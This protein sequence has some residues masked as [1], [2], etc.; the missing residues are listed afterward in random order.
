VIESCASGGARVDLGILART[1]RVWA[2]DTND[3]LERQTIQRWTQLLLPPELVGSHVGPPTAHTT[4]RTHRLSFRGATALF[5]HLGIEWDLVSASADERRDVAALVATY[6]THR[7]LL[8]SGTVV[9]ADH[10]DPSV[11]VHGVVAAD[12]SEALL[13]YVTVATSAA[14]V[15]VPAR[16]PGLDREARYTVEPVNTGGSPFTVQRAGPPWWPVDGEA[17]PVL[18]GSF[19]TDVG[20]PMPVLGPEQAVVLHL[21][22]T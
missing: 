18:P 20:L 8:H 4:G 10:P 17:A 13:A 6:K 22:R 15:P 9:H 19:L 16:L 5:G 14:A 12:R 1:D 2:S 11:L 3:A 7:D 21:R